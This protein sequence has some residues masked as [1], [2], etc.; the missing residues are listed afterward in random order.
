MGAFWL[1]GET[2]PTEGYLAIFN[3]K[4]MTSCRMLWLLDGRKR[5]VNRNEKGRGGREGVCYVLGSR[6]RGDEDHSQSSV[7][8]LV[9]GSS[10]QWLVVDQDGF[11][12]PS[13][14][15]S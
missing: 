4:Q 5:E 3:R 8:W 11:P 15:I 14:P 2:V 6:Q 10:V 7:Q 1:Q 9:V 12:C 13:L